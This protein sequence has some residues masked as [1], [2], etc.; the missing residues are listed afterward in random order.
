MPENDDYETVANILKRKL[1]KIRQAPLD[2]GSLSWDDILGE[3]WKSVKRKAQQRKG[4]LDMPDPM[5]RAA[6]VHH[7]ARGPAGQ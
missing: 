5:A 7:D 4:F 2:P 3:T 1:G 6:I